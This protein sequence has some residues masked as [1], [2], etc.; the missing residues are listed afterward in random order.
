MT[1][2]RYM[3]FVF[4]FC[5]L[6]NSKLQEGLKENLFT[7]DIHM[8]LSSFDTCLCKQ[9]SKSVI[10]LKHN[11]CSIYWSFRVKEASKFSDK[12]RAEPVEATQQVSIQKISHDK[13]PVFSNPDLVNQD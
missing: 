8:V 4:Y 9:F 12:N 5:N 3:I 1:C 13:K 11:E 7:P 6:I 10:L 2:S